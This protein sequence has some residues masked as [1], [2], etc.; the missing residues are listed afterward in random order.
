MFHDCIAT[1]TEQE[2][3]FSFKCFGY[4][5][6]NFRFT[7]VVAGRADAEPVLIDEVLGDKPESRVTTLPAGLD[8]DDHVVNI[9]IRICN[10]STKACS[11]VTLPLKVRCL[12]NLLT[13]T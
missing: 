2:T 7:Y 4:G 8:S 11:L 6:Q 3:K 10:T 13:I 12:L 1:G 9:K 5:I